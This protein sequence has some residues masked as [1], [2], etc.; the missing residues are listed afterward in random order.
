MPGHDGNP[1][2]VN[3]LLTLGEN[4]A[5]AGGITAAFYA[6]KKRDENSP[7]PVLP[8]LNMFTKEQLFFISYANWWCGKSTNEA[9]EA[10]IYNDPHA[11][12][13]ARIIVSQVNDSGCTTAYSAIFGLSPSL[14]FAVANHVVGNNGQFSGI[15]GG[16]PLSQSTPNVQ[17]LVNCLFFV[18]TGYAMHESFGFKIEL[19]FFFFPFSFSFPPLL[20]ASTLLKRRVFF[21]F[22][23]LIVISPSCFSFL[24]L[25]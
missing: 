24:K 23:G 8:G 11:P 17:T 21:L 7:D 18:V 20:L 22:G 6:W 2:H 3:G 25:S 9:A 12:K 1:L 19:F 13:R 10:A 5:D 14:S 4:I 15:Q 16:F